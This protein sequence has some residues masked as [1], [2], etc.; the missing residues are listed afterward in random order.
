M[1]RPMVSRPVC[2][3]VKHPSGAYDQIFITFR[4]LRVCC[5]GALSLTRE[6]VCNLQLLLVS[7]AQSI[8]G[9]SPAGFVTIFY[10]LRFETPPTW[11]ARSPYLYPPETGW[12]SYNP[13]HWVPSSSPPTT[14][15]ATVEVFE[16]ASTRA[17]DQISQW[18]SLYS[19]DTDRRKNTASKISS[20]FC[21]NLLLR[22]RVYTVVA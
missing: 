15:R 13:R 18:F 5:C 11:R 7:P 17:S 22:K 16:P 6:R 1:L 4:K 10:C 19:P 9:P 14:C 21:V 2:L 12:P 20:I 8:L 3:G